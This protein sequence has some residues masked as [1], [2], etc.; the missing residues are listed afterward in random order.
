MRK[1]K[2]IA[3][4]YFA[5]CQRFE[6]VNIFLKGVFDEL[7]NTSNIVE[8]EK[9]VMKIIAPNDHFAQEIR[10]VLKAK[11]TFLFSNKE[12]LNAAMPRIEIYLLYDLINCLACDYCC[13]VKR[14][15][16]RPHHK[17]TDFY[18]QYREERSKINIW[19]IISRVLLAYNVIN[20]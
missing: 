4:K 18:D 20:L 8:K 14:Q 11:R 16:K 3:E 7:L 2:T 6:N 1:T 17:N 10:L 5:F 19:Q 12:K 15:A 9:L 13:K